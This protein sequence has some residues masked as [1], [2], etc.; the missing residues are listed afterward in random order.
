MLNSSSGITVAICNA[1]T[2]VQCVKN[3]DI[4]S[5]INSFTVASPDG[6]PV[7]KA[8]SKLAKNIKRVDGYKV[9]KQTI[10]DGL[11]KILHIIFLVVVKELFHA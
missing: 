8:I 11:E 4:N 10:K 6:F 2:L 5:V 7:A 1:N 9:F 3:N